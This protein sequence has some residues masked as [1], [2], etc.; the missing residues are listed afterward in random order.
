M[1]EAS[2]T[3]GAQDV[4]QTVGAIASV[5]TPDG[6][7]P[8]FPGGVTNPWNHVEAAMAL[9]VGGLHERARR[10]YEWSRRNQRPD[11][12]WCGGYLETEVVDHTL[13]T[14]F[15]AYIAFGVWHH[16]LATG[17]RGFLTDM[18]PTVERA[19]ASTLALQR[20][21]GAIAWARDG[22]GRA[23]KAALLTSCAC[24]AM[25]LRSALAIAGELHEPRPKWELAQARLGAALAGGD[26]LFEPKT[27]FSMDW[28]YPV[29]ARCLPEDGARRRL[30]GRWDEFVVSGL[31]ARCVSDRPWVTSGETAELAIALHV[32]GMEAEAD[33]MLAWVDHLRAGDGAYWIGATFHDRTVWPRQKPTWGSGSVV[34]AA[35]VLAGGVTASCF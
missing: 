3:L 11:G 16:Y 23:A 24:I 28:Y 15:T 1:L 6:A 19:V 22:R 27:R 25:S 26:H 17:D 21:D 8:E 33:L 5:Q 12:S 29:L 34:L 20:E 31:G 9:D 18:W 14:N 10:A 30:R 13:D 32:A 4:A 2:V 7:I 35:D